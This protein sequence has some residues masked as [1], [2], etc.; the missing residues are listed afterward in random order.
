MY[1]LGGN[2]CPCPHRRS[3][4][5]DCYAKACMSQSMG[6]SVESGVSVL[7]VFGVLLVRFGALRAGLLCHSLFLFEVHRHQL[8]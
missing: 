7:N 4:D 3:N 1:A 8:N 5:H 2:V 6:E